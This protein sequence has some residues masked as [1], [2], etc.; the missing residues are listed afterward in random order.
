M[1]LQSVV[2]WTLTQS[3]TGTHLRM[4]HAGFRPDQERAFQGAGYGW[5][6]FLA[7]LEGVL[8]EAE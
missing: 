5:Q 1:G 4:E 8:A 2:T 3:G 6:Q 7:K